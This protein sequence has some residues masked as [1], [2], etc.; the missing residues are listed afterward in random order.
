MARKNNK[1]TFK[2]V[3]LF[4]YKNDFWS[5]AELRMLTNMPKYYERIMY[6]R[7]YF[8]GW[9]IRDMVELPLY[10]YTYKCRDKKWN[11]K[12]RKIKVVVVD[13]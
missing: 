1:R 3:T 9:S 10:T 11:E 5:L 2:F 8:Y 7:Y 6:C 4:W 13:K 12:K